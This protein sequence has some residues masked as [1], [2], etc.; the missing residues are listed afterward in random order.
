[1]RLN[2]LNL[3]MLVYLDAL[4][5]E[6]NVSKAADRVHLTQ[7]AMSLALRRLR[8]HFHDEILRKVGKTMVPT[9][10]ALSLVQPLQN[11]LIQIQSIVSSRD[12]FD[13]AK[14]NRKITMTG[15]DFT[16]DLLLKKVLPKLSRIAPGIRID[17]VALSGSRDEEF[18][19]GRIDLLV[20]PDVY[21]IEGH[22]SEPLLTAEFAC[23][24]WS[25]NALVR[26]SISFEQ[27]TQMGHV[28]VKLGD[29]RRGTYKEQWFLEH[30]GDIRRIE[31]EVPSFALAVQLVSGTQRIATCH[32]QHARMYARQ[33]SLRILAPPFNIPPSRLRLQWHK[34]MDGDPALMWF[35]GVLKEAVE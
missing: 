24:V 22:P 30:Y 27:Y 21:A 14:S 2:D 23:V 13:P 7:S 15:S 8:D 12:N 17:Y 19:Q 31:V 10:L 9:P 6:R 26:D 3:N 11:V 28:C 16:M 5:S 33:Y 4:L 25:K 34:H 20:L 29:W 35:R 18:M 1:M 32:I